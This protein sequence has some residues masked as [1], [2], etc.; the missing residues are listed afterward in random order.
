[1]SGVFPCS[2]DFL[3]QVRSHRAGCGPVARRLSGDG[4]TP[5]SAFARLASPNRPAFLFESVMGGEKLGR[6]S[7]IGVEP[8]LWF[9]AKGH[10]MTIASPQ[11]TRH[12]FETADPLRV[13]ERWIAAHR[14]FPLPGLPS[15]LGGAVGFAGYDTVR[16]AERLP[17]PPPDD[18]TLP[19][20]AFGLY[21]QI[22]V[23][24]HIRKRVVVAVVAR[25]RDLIEAAANPQ[26][27]TEGLIRGESLV[28]ATD[29]QWLEAH[30]RALDR[31][32]HL[33]GRLNASTPI[34]LG[35]TDLDLTPTADPPYE[36]NFDQKGYEAVVSRC[37]E[38][39]RAGDIFQV[40]PSQ[41][42]RLVTDSR[43]FDI[44]RALRVVNPSPF[45]FYLDH[46]AYQLIGSSPEIMMRVHQG[47]MTVRPLAGTRRRGA[48]D[49]EDRRLERELLADPKER[50]EHVMLID[51]G[52]NDVGRVAR[53]SSVRL[54]NVMHVERY[55]HVKHISTDVHGELV[56]GLTAFDALRASLPVGTVSGAPKIRAMEIIDEL[57]T[58]RR[59]PYAGAV[60]YVDFNGDMDTCIALRTIVRHG[61]F[62]DVQAGAGIVYD[63]DPTTEYQETLAKARGLFQAINL[64]ESFRATGPPTPT[65]S[66]G[67]STT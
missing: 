37:Q 2:A 57:E 33:I 31:L 66:S 48:T 58:T 23:F 19:D 9:E 10:R 34:D 50:A 59:G 64:A 35:L 16:Y 6:Y 13:L 41:R 62:A 46:G 7:F 47:R 55:S 60:G 40:V 43:S 18:R 65:G 3:D 63:S 36:S 53:P 5:V 38:Y 24:D 44:Y 28:E 56:E 39:I 25:P 20:L 67:D 17:N 32:D 22:L 15:F 42:F 30:D 1:M 12:E 4:L 61:R 29:S 26:T 51:L 52:R 11:G 14:A 21:D 27:A 45:L 8:F 49:E 54:D